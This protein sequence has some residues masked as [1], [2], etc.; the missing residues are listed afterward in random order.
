M[1]IRQALYQQ[2][3]DTAQTVFA[4]AEVYPRGVSPDHPPER[5][6]VY[7]QIDQ[8]HERH[9]EAGSEITHPRFQLGVWTRDPDDT[10]ALFQAIREAFDNFRGDMGSAPETLERVNGA[11]I[12]TDETQFEP[13]R[14]AGPGG[15]YG[16]LIDLTV[17]HGESRSPVNQ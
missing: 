13:G 16:H 4:D 3:R 5:Y 14:D 7:E 12:E 2:L 8:V 15:W 6:V 11:F 1:T 9:L 17:W 10:D